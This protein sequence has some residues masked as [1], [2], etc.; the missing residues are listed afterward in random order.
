MKRISLRLTATVVSILT[1]A[2]CLTPSAFAAK[3]FAPVIDTQNIGVQTQ[4]SYSENDPSWL[5]KLVVKEDLMSVEGIAT[6]SVLYPN[7]SYPYRTDAPCF[8]EEVAKYVENFTLDEEGRKAAY[9]YLLK[10]IGAISIITETPEEG[11]SKADWLREQGIII[12]EEEEAD[13]D[14]IILINALYSLMKND[15][16]YVYSGNHIDIPAG[17]RLEPALMMYLMAMTS[18][19]STLTEFLQKYFARTQILTLEDYIYYTSLMALFSGGF[20]SVTELPTITPE[21]VYRRV[22]IMTIRTAGISVDSDTATTEEIQI[23][24]LASMLSDTYNISVDPDALEKEVKKGTVAYYIIRR[25]AYEDA[26]ISISDKRY[27]YEEAFK[28]VLKQTHRFDL[29]N[30]FYCDIKEY[31]VYLKNIRDSVYINPVPLS[32]SGVEIM[33][34]GTKVEGNQYYKALLTGE[35][36]QTIG[37]A[38][39]HKSGKTVK[40]TY[41]RLKIY[42]GVEAATDSNLTGFIESFGNITVQNPDVSL[43]LPAPAGVYDGVSKLNEVVP[44]LYQLADKML[45]M[46]E[47]GQ[48]VD[49]EGNIISAESYE[50]LPEGYK[51]SLDSAGNIII[52]PVTDEPT[53]VSSSENTDA[54]QS[55]ENLRYILIAGSVFLF[56]LLIFI[57]AIIIRLTS[58][59]KKSKG[60]SKKAKEKAKKARKENRA[61]KRNK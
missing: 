14:S 2:A 57:I 53:T 55:K 47:Y 17:T 8:K 24:Y 50:T 41:Y 30:E 6:E 16:Y 1:V 56:L 22:A 3:K 27:K 28:I 42:N 34:N 52:V 25:M 12:T 38:V 43:S 59:N 21:E 61:R 40:N 33:I 51:Y 15:F 4:Y 26:S 9:I 58:K 35:A 10:Q 11:Q 18:K 60:K 48:L 31:G 37:I 49:N 36:P 39:T 13:P 5:R 44:S 23:K 29:E 7:A 19:N 54:L 46:N 20:V 45:R 32:L